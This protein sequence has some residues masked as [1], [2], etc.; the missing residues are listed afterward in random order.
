[1]TH[2]MAKGKQGSA[3][4]GRGRA[5]PSGPQQE[6]EE[7]SSTAGGQNQ[8]PKYQIKAPSRPRKHLRVGYLLVAAPAGCLV[9]GELLLHMGGLVHLLGVKGQAAQRAQRGWHLQA[10]LEA[11]PAEPAGGRGQGAWAPAHMGQQLSAAN[12]VFLE[13][14]TSEPKSHWLD[15]HHLAKGFPPSCGLLGC[16]AISRSQ[17]E[18]QMCLYR[19]CAGRPQG[20]GPSESS[21]YSR[22]LGLSFTVSPPPSD[23]KTSGGSEDTETAQG[24]L[25]TIHP[26]SS[27]E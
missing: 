9:G 3:L 21:G 14:L 5:E 11:L 6:R 18:L 13:T 25:E 26:L 22:R 10:W 20:P 12:C 17:A 8:G 16:S 2:S 23:N 4:W 24:T 7:P 27:G 15:G 19:T 1:M